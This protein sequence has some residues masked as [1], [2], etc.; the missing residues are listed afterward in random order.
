MLTINNLS[1]TFGVKPVLSNVSFQL[2]S[3]KKTG[4][5]GL[6]GGGK[7]TLIRVITG[8][9][10]P[11]GGSVIFNPPDL[12][13]GYLKQGLILPEEETI[14]TY[15]HQLSGNMEVISREVE[16]LASEL[17]KKP[18]DSRLAE[19]YNRAL[20]FL[21]TASEITGGTQHV[22]TMLGLADIPADL[23]IRQLSGGQKTRLGL[24]G[25]LLTNPQ[26]LLLDEPTNHLDIAM[27]EWL[28]DWLIQ[29]RCAAL[30]VSHDRTFL[31]AVVD[32]ILELDEHT[33]SVREFPG[34]YSDYLRQKQTERE[35]QWRDFVDQQGEIRRLRS[36][37]SGVRDLARYHKGGKTDPGKTDGFSIGFFANRGK[38]TTQRAKNLE[39]RIEHL[40]TD[41]RI[42]KPARTWQM[43]VDF[44]KTTESG[45]DVVILENLSIGY[46]DRVL[47]GPITLTVRSG[48]RIVLSG[49]NGCGKSTLLK[50]ITGNIPAL[51]G[52]VRLGS[53][54]KL[55]YL[56]QDQETLDAS[57]TVLETLLRV[58]SQSETE[59]RSFLS[60]YLFT[61]D[62]VFSSVSQLSYGERVR[63]SL[64]CLVAEGCNLLIMDEPINHL[65]IPSRERF[66]QALD[67]FPGTVLV[68]VH[69]RTFIKN[70]ARTVWKFADQQ[71][72]IDYSWDLQ[73]QTSQ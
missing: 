51:A 1:K 54:V 9:I 25:V 40:L 49:P 61:G 38:E 68:V 69:D 34:N 15:L 33:H 37:A 10:K 56:A 19:A 22:L 58:N 46:P 26:L 21:Q 48:D 43:K 11:D 62:D 14:S 44:E 29:M 18:E 4:L 41:E 24:A 60:K 27:L 59:T 35:K 2:N 64:A 12:R 47:G 67:G 36:A 32:S 6:N 52:T 3:G 28:E 8:E 45:R 55:G 31:D 53:G 39:K 20:S 16:H 7:T 5:I 63:L 42:D 30:I 65:D 50:T 73:S 70:F 13:I 72:S 71:I 57:L 23:R 66:E 17:A